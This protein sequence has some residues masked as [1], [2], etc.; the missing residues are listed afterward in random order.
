MLADLRA[1]A[2]LALVT[3][4]AVLADTGASAHG[5]LG[6]LSP[7]RADLGAATVL[8]LR[9]ASVVLTMEDFA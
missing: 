4:S 9:S 7:M 5:A 6:L 2:L 3:T 1:T 8:A